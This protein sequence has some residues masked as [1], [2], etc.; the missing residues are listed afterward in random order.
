MAPHRARFVRRPKTHRGEFEIFAAR[1][2]SRS[3]QGT[4][5]IEP[6]REKQRQSDEI[7]EDRQAGE[8]QGEKRRDARRDRFAR[9]AAGID[10]RAR[11]SLANV[12]EEKSGDQRDDRRDQKRQPENQTEPDE[13]GQERRQPAASARG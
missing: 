5:H 2:D 10:R 4:R 3:R 13:P 12:V 8:A 9:C 11:R 7:D 1:A 6:R